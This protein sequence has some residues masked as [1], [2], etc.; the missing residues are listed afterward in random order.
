MNNE[1][2]T[3]ATQKRLAEGD[4]LRI[5][6]NHAS[7]ETIHLLFV[8]LSSKE[9]INIPLLERIGIDPKKLLQESES[10]L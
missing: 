6:R 4:S 5:E 9:S 10:F 8:I 7:L 3:I 2:F 1:N